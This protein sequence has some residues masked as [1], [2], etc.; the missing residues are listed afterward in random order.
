M[1]KIGETLL[2]MNDVSAEEAGI[3]DPYL[4]KGSK[5]RVV[6]VI[7]KDTVHALLLSRNTDKSYKSPNGVF[8]IMLILIIREDVDNGDVIS[9]TEMR[10]DKLSVILE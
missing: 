5:L 3:K 1:F 10:D 9:L 4:S 6:N 8:M 2:V 7:D